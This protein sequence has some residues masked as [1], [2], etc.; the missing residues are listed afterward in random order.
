MDGGWNLLEA[1]DVKSVSESSLKE[2][3]RMIEP[4]YV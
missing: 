4:G 2:T 1:Y 3:W